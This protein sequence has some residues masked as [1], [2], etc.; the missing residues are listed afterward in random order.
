[1]GKNP[2]RRVRKPPNPTVRDTDLISSPEILRGLEAE[3]PNVLRK[4]N[5]TEKARL[6]GAVAIM[7]S[8]TGPIPPP[9]LLAQFNEIIPNGADR[10][11]TMAEKQQEHRFGLEDKSLSANL[12]ESGRGQIFG[13]VLVSLAIL[14]AVYMIFTGKTTEGTILIFGNIGSL[15]AVYLKSKSKQDK[16][17]EKKARANP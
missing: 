7:T 12:K 2:S 11:M 10:I 15:L 17:L 9:E 4:L 6:V 14:L 8:Y 1:M 5:P 13:F 3:A 16:D